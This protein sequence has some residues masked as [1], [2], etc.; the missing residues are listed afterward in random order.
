[1]EQRAGEIVLRLR[2]V[3]GGGAGDHQ[4]Q[5]EGGFHLQHLPAGVPHHSL[6]HWLLRSA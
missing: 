6:L 5:M 4:G 3:Q 1:M 2:V